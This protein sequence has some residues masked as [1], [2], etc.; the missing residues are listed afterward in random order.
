MAKTFS[1]GLTHVQTPKKTSQ[2][3]NHSK[4][5]M[6]SMNKNQKRSYKRYKGQGR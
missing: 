1:G 4:V 2:N 5:K 6:S 3:G